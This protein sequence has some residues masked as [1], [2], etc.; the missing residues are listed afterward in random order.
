MRQGANFAGRILPVLAGVKPVIFA[1]TDV[2]TKICMCVKETSREA[3]ST[4]Q[5]SYATNI[6]QHVM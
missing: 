6:L 3:I 1:M 2:K 4:Y 5:V